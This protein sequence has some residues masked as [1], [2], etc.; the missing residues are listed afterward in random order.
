MAKDKR[1]TVENTEIDPTGK[2]KLPGQCMKPGCLSSSAKEIGNA[3]SVC[4]AHGDAQ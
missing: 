2:N 4:P 1:P 3:N